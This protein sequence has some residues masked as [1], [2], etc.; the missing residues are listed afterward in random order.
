MEKFLILFPCSLEQGKV[1]NKGPFLVA[2]GICQL[3]Q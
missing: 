1:I 3:S 2:L